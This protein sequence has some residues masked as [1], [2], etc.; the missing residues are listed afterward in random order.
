MRVRLMEKYCLDWTADK[1]IMLSLYWSLWKKK[2]GKT[3]KST[4][5][6]LPQLKS[7]STL[8]RPI[9]S[10]QSDVNCYLNA[11]L[12]LLNCLLLVFSLT[13]LVVGSGSNDFGRETPLKKKRAQLVFS[14]NF[15]GEGRE[16]INT[17]IMHED[18]IRS[19]PDQSV[20][21]LKRGGRGFFQFTVRKSREGRKE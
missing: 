19:R 11:P 10:K 5:V 13:R 20:N 21:D 17:L 15:T 16:R 8:G 9:Q 3:T 7:V 6:Y 4:N 18:V 1:L 2:K 14:I 12:C